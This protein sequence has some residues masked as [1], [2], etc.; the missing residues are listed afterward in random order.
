MFKTIFAKL[1]AVFIAI[2]IFSF[3]VVGVILYFFIG[4]Y[5]T[6]EK[7]TKLEQSSSEIN[8]YLTEYINL[9]NDPIV[10]KNFL[11]ILRLYKSNTNSLIWVVNNDGRIVISENDIPG[12]DIPHDIKK[13][14]IQ[15][16]GYLKLPDKRQ[17][18][19]VML[20]KKTVKD[21]G[22]F[23]GL[24]KDTG[25]AWLTIEKPVLYTD[26]TGKQSVMYAVYLSTPIPEINKV[27]IMLLKYFLLAVLVSVIL[28]V[29]IIYYVSRKISKPLKDIQKAAK[30]ISAGEFQKRLTV[31]SKDEVGELAESFNQM[32]EALQQ[33]EVMRRDFTAN[34]SHELRTPL[35]SIRGFVEGIIDGTIP[36]EKQDMY[37]GL[38]REE[39]NRLNRLI[40]DLL[41]LTKIESGET[42]LRLTNFD[43]NELIRRCIIKQESL[44]VEKNI[45]VE[46]DFE[47]ENIF[48]NADSDAIERVLINL[49][50][51]SGKF[52]NEGGKIKLAVHRQKG[53]IYVVEEDNGIG[54]EKNE[55]NLI[56]G[57]FF[58][59]DKS[60]GH[61]KSGTGLGLSIIRN[62]IDLHG[63]KI[64]V[65]S[66]T[67]K[68]TKFT[69]TLNEAIYN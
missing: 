7:T 34:V 53:R 8:N 3:S 59:S 55:I 49:I 62:I 51:N 18:Q 60:R 54:I 23:Y 37:L 28:S 48:V 13:N 10:F 6:D 43:I 67:G 15:V 14:L 32:A 36:H 20:G 58:K 31:E 64:W 1:I 40:N 45:Q 61:D 69:F 21:T 22:D 65:E 4:N 26:I 42:K 35:T 25:L 16:P 5:V 17:Y 66:E 68:G 30:H 39:T 44:L 24:F 33:I 50:H 12:M 57:R 38:V 41:E 19:E 2:L 47:E 63:Q 52:T 9:I 11:Y 27:R 46:L 56:W 29:I